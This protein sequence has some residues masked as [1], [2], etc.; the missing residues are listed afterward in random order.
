MI[1]PL[2]R[3]GYII[4]RP[5]N[6]KAGYA[7]NNWFYSCIC[8]IKF[9]QKAIDNQIK[10]DKKV[11]ECSEYKDQTSFQKKDQELSKHSQ[12]S[13]HEPREQPISFYI[14]FPSDNQMYTLQNVAKNIDVEWRKYKVATEDLRVTQNLGSCLE[15]FSA[16]P[17]AI[18]MPC[19]HG[20]CCLRCSVKK[21]NRP[22]LCPFCSKVVEFILEM[23]E[24]I[25]EITV[26][27]WAEWKQSISYDVICSLNSPR[28]L[29]N[30]F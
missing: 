20:G 15:C 25:Q 26:E 19:S 10:F 28:I 2:E 3:V 13:I 14:I 29:R 8:A 7:G 17:L 1:V 6:V 30:Y 22:K 16:R 4:H 12:S 21:N 9:S 23:G 5:G 24:S 11:D 18:F 27:D